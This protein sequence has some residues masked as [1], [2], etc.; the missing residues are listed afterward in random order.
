MLDKKAKEQLERNREVLRSILRCLAFCGG[1]GIALR[2]HRDDDTSTD[3]DTSLGNLKS[4]LSLCCQS[5]DHVLKQHL[6]TCAKNAKYTSKTAQNDLLLCIKRYTQGKIIDKVKV[7]PHGPL[8]G[9]QADEVTDVSNK[10]QLGVVLRYLQNDKPVERLIDFIECK[11]V[12]GEAL[13]RQIVPKID[14]VGLDM[15]N[16]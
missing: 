16:C 13:A 11:E 14:Q 4:L 9:V 3:A 8:F 2:G 10:E 12:T 7:Q 1:Q 5:G 6:E 15:K